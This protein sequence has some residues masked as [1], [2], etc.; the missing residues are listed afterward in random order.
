MVRYVAFRVYYKDGT[1]EVKAVGG[2]A[3][4]QAEALTRLEAKETRM[5]TLTAELGPI[6][7]E[8]FAHLAEEE[9]ERVMDS[10]ERMRRAFNTLSDDQPDVPDLFLGLVIDILALE[11]RDPPSK[12]NELSLGSG[13]FQVLCV[14][15]RTDGIAPATL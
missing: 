15:H 14:C 11:F 12:I 8:I 6:M 13:R 7:D 5:K 4:E 9:R 1:G 2:T 3:E 10:P